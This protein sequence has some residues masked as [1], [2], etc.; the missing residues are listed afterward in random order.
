[1]NWTCSVSRQSS[2]RL[3]TTNHFE[4]S[5]PVKTLFDCLAHGDTMEEFLY[6]FEGV[7]REQAEAV[8]ELALL[9]LILFLL[10]I[11]ILL[12]LPSPKRRA[13]LRV[14]LR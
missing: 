2:A 14:R 11:F 8:L 4:C 7:D 12:F 1:M 6:D 13:G 10:V 5:V 3:A 9:L